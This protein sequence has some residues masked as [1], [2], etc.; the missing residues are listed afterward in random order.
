M[1]QMSLLATDKYNYWDWSKINQ[2]IEFQKLKWKLPNSLNKSALK[3]TDIM[4]RKYR[5]SGQ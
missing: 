2:E 4:L 1:N 3:P 5:L